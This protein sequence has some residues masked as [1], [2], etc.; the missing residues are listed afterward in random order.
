M[1]NQRSYQGVLH[2]GLNMEHPI[3]DLLKHI[4]GRIDENVDESDPAFQAIVA[5]RLLLSS[6]ARM[7]DQ[8]QVLEERMRIQDIAMKLGASGT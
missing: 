6:W 8:T 3:Y 1:F 5:L 4:E 7:E 2:I